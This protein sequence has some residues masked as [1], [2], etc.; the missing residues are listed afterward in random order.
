MS[1]TVSRESFRFFHSLRVRW[2]EVDLQ[3]IVFNGNYLTYAD[4]GI[5]EYFRELRVA[6]PEALTADGC[7]FYA[8]KTT[9]EYK[10]PAHFDEMLEIGVRIARLGSSSLSFELGIWKGEQ[11]LTQGEIVYVHARTQPR[12][13]EPL[14]D[15]FR[16]R[17]GQFELTP[18]LR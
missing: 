9:L 2:A 7:D 15:W 8:I 14:P 16:E 18:P 10:A 4:V 13:S 11:L 6:Y 1:T 3:G 5:T 12:G 17:V